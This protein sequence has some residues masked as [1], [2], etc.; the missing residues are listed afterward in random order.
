MPTVPHYHTATVRQAHNHIA[1]L[2]E[3]DR[4]MNKRLICIKCG[5]DTF[6]VEKEEHCEY[7]DHT[8]NIKEVTIYTCAKCLT[9][10]ARWE[11]EQ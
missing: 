3:G 9:S 1:S 7:E 6:H 8:H 10:K 5:N 4:T 11:L 2:H